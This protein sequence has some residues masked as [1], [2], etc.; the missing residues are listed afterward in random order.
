[1]ESAL[2]PREIQ[3]RVRAGESLEDVALAAGVPMERIEA[4]AVPVLAERVYLAGQAAESPVRRRSETSSTRTLL[5]AI[6]ERLTAL[7]V[8]RGEVSWDAWKLENRRW[9]VVA[10][11]EGETPR[12]G[13]FVFDLDRRFS[14]ATN[15]DAHWLISDDEEAPAQG[16]R[17]G[18]DPD[19]EPTLDLDD[20]LALVRA[21]DVER[22]PYDDPSEIGDAYS[23]GDLTEVDGIYDII[24]PS[25]DM[26]VLYDMLSSFNEDSV[27]IYR[28]LTTPVV[29]EPE[30]AVVMPPED[31]APP[32]DEPEPAEQPEPEPEP[33][34]ESELSQEPRP[35]PEQ[36]ALLDDPAPKPKSR[37]R[38]SR[39][40]A[41]VP[42]WDEI[43]FGSPNVP[44][45]PR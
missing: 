38:K 4:F 7:G 17:R 31:G 3:A 28:G 2:R 5:D 20:E 23:P 35:E 21:V 30:D 43:M 6:T 10:E 24:P 9:Q 34:R 11:V 19:S 37:T 39:K 25:T 29:V 12:R 16:K 45:D 33:G 27:Q 41:S 15:D 1:M 44:K 42:S 14:I 36:K 40:R 8:E 26:D 22:S 18:D 32:G 13:T